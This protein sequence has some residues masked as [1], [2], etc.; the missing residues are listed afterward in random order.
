MKKLLR[1]LADKLLGGSLPPAVWIDT[2]GTRLPWL[3]LALTLPFV[4]TGPI[5]AVTSLGLAFSL[6]LSL[7][8]CMGTVALLWP[9]LRGRVAR[10]PSAAEWVLETVALL[11]VGLAVWALYIRDFGGFPNLDGWDGG[12]H[13]FLKSVFGAAIP[14]VYSSQVAC[15]AFVWWLEKL[16][17]LNALQSFAA[18]F[19]VSVA[20]MVAFPLTIT[21]ALVRAESSACRAARFAGVGVT[22]LAT[23]GLLLLA[24]LPLLHYNQAAGYYVHLFGFLPL[25]MLWAADALI[26]LHRLRVAV[27]IGTFVLLRYT[28]ALNLA[29]AAIAVAFVLLVEGFR[30]RWRILQGLLV[31]GLC[32]VAVQVVSELRP[33]FRVWGGMQRFDVDK[34]FK[35]DVLVLGA[36][37]AYLL[38]TAWQPFPSGWLSS[39][40][41]R[42]IRFPLSFSAASS[43]I[44]LVLRKGPNVKYYYVTK[45]QIWACLLL[46]FVLVILLGHLAATLA[47]LSSMRRPT[48]WLRVAVVTALLVTVPSLWATTFA[49]YATSLRERMGPHALV[50]RHLRPLVDEQSLPRIRAVLSAEH[51]AFGGYLTAFFP[52]F[53]FMNATL[54]YHGSQELFFAPAT[55]PGHCVFWVAKAHDTYPLGPV[56]KLNAL[57][58]QVAAAGATCAEYPVPWKSTPQSLCYHCY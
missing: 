45:Y 23:V 19:Y 21:F 31:V 32:L 24:G 46:G 28:Y 40:L 58:D 33:I 18:A 43:A 16:F 1:A 5:R 37:L 47:R 22:V 15:Y 3:L 11:P 27:L 17:Q 48:V 25:M 10:A 9:W 42:A 12:T 4:L 38:A 13:V 52:M 41:F 20:A 14:D 50:Y 51:K 56:D 53:S 35:A 49:G 6:V 55:T 29:D 8:F 2:R 54:G 39:P 34:V 30:G 57:R 26:R 36:L 44:F 7:V